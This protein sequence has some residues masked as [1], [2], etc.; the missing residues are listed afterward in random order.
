[1]V[2]VGQARDNLEALQ[3]ARTDVDLIMLGV[4]HVSPC[5]G[6][7]SHLLSESPHLKI[8]SI[9]AGH[10]IGRAYWLGVRQRKVS[11]ASTTVLLR[12]IRRLYQIDAMD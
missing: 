4:Q 6:I 11:V 9:V 3:A 7:C 12:N 8:L 2:L 10:D 5:P 1:M